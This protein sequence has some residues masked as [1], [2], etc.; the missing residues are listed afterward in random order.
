MIDEKLMMHCIK[1]LVM[2]Y[3][4]YRNVKSDGTKPRFT[5]NWILGS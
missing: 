2:H 4:M 5:D 3:T 1:A